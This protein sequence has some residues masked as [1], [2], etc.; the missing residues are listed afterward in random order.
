MAI[1]TADF[2]IGMNIKYNGAPYTIIKCEFMNPGKGSAVYRTKL[3][4]IKTGKVLD[5]TFKSGEKVEEDDHGNIRLGGISEYI[6]EA[7]KADLVDGIL[8][9]TN[10]VFGFTASDNK[11]FFA[12]NVGQKLYFATSET[13]R[14]FISSGKG[15]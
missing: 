15:L 5:V 12:V 11:F 13:K 4:G 7:F 8:P 9:V 14:R 6:V 10:I 3:R 1:S 2:K